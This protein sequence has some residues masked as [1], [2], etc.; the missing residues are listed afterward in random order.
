MN[1]DSTNLSI[2]KLFGIQ[3]ENLVGFD[4]KVSAGTMPIIV[5]K[6]LIKQNFDAHLSEII[7]EVK[8]KE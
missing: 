1:V 8:V 6:Y 2:A 5:A 4:I 3:T 7:F